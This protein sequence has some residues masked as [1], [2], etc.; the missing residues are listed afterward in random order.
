[1]MGIV[2]AV[3]TTGVI[4]VVGTLPSRKEAIMLFV[5]VE[6]IKISSDRIK[7]KTNAAIKIFAKG[8]WLRSK[9]KR[10][11]DKSSI[12]AKTYIPK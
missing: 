1:M 10:S 3:S 8:H 12:K 6:F 11:E 2:R 7:R 9:R 5:P 4:N